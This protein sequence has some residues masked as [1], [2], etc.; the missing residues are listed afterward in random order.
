MEGDD[1]VCRRVA[2]S[3]HR[4]DSRPFFFLLILEKSSQQTDRFVRYDRE[5]GERKRG[6]KN[7]AAIRCRRM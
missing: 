5:V 4:H 3:D 6:R 7:L 2:L 1:G